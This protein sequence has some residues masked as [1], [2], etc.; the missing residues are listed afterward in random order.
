MSVAC[1]PVGQSYSKKYLM[2]T[3]LYLHHKVLQRELPIVYNSHVAINA[4]TSEAWAP[5]C[6]IAE[7]QSIF[8]KLVLRDSFDL[9]YQKL[10]NSK[11][12]KDQSESERDQ[13]ARVR[14]QEAMM[15]FE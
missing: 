5:L 6:K 1:Q 10:N 2:A 13:R 14:D 11:T 12:N 4:V 9:F 15:L 3:L 8:M 7:I